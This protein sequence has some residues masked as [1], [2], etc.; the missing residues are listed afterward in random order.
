[1]NDFVLNPSQFVI[2]SPPGDT[3]AEIL[4]ARGMTQAELALRTGRPLKTINEIIKGKAAITP[5]TALQFERVLGVSANFWLNR[6]QQY[7]ESQARQA[8]RQAL[9]EQADWVEKFPLQ[10]MV[11]MGWLE[12][13]SDSCDQVQELLRFFGLAR[14]QDWLVYWTSTIPE[15]QHTQSF[16]RDPG[17]LTAWLRQGER[18]ALRIKCAPYHASTLRELLPYLGDLMDRQVDDFYPDLVNMLA[19]SGVAFCV[20]PAL[21]GQSNL[22]LVRRLSPEK[23]LLQISSSLDQPREFW[24]ALYHSLGHILLHGKRQV[25]LEADNCTSQAHLAEVER[26]ARPYLDNWDWGKAPL[27]YSWEFLQHQGQTQEEEWEDIPEDAAVVQPAA[28]A[29]TDPL[30]LFNWPG[31]SAGARRSLLAAG[32]EIEAGRVD[33]QLFSHWV[34]AQLVSIQDAYA[35]GYVRDALADLDN[36]ARLIHLGAKISPALDG[37][38]QALTLI[39]LL[40]QQ[41]AQPT[42]DP[43]SQ[44]RSVIQETYQP[45]KNRMVS[46]T[47]LSYAAVATRTE[48]SLAEQFFHHE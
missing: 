32:L 14:P 33:E 17:S 6:E 11:R 40:V 44:L 13:C 34:S 1:M 45:I 3:L 38:S 7:R 24:E 22:R 23:A 41:G 20:V 2:Q 8:E 18:L 39:K 36:L 16:Q 9:Q 31:L 35:Q 37:L 43:R 10:D 47:R 28:A 42:L 15:L 12:D 27:A 5:E 30:A 4:A 29:P 26:F 46:E 25:Y 21:P 48:N 19:H